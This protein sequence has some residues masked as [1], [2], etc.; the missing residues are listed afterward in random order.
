[1]SAAREMVKAA[2][3]G[4]AARPLARLAPARPEG[5]GRRLA[6]RLGNEWLPRAAW[7]L[8]RTGRPGLV[9]MALLLAAALFLF[10]THLRVA[11]EVQALREDLAAA[12]ARGRRTAADGGAGPA[13]A[14]RVLP[15]RTEVPEILRRLFEEAGRARLSVDSGKYEVNA[16]GGGGVV[17]YRI[18]FP[19][20][21]PYPQIRAFID[22]ALAGLPE[23]GL[24]DLTFQRKAIGDG[25]VEAQIRMTVYTTATDA[26]GPAPAPA[27]EASGR[28]VA[29]EHA[30]ALFAQHSWMVLPPPIKPA[31]PPPPPEPT[32]PPLPYT[33]LGSFTPEG[34]PP[35]YFLARG[36]RVVDAHVGDRLDGVY[37]FESAGG[38]QLVF[39]YLPLNVRQ[40]LA[41]GVVR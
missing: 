13:A 4:A 28:A 33:F 26:G 24:A 35:V 21:G 15:A 29:P 7:T 20:T 8:S 39:V 34:K 36:D 12:Q 40:T 32:A 25:G 41:G 19:V 6:A 27:A 3:P 16:A 38:G 37:E 22:A 2:A 11:S 1:M 23:L 30:A 10:S 5:L 17:R 9:G 14:R 18:A 31:P